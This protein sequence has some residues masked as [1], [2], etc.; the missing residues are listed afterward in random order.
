MEPRY[1][2]AHTVATML[3]VVK[4]QVDAA[5]IPGE[6]SFTKFLPNARLNF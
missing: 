1:G 4:V 2:Y 5:S 3:G 6:A